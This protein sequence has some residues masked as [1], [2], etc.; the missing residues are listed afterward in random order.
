MLGVVSFTLLSAGVPCNSL[1]WSAVSCCC[2]P[3]AVSCHVKQ[4]GKPCDT[5]PDNDLP[6]GAGC[7]PALRRAACRPG[8][9]ICSLGNAASSPYEKCCAFAAQQLGEHD[10][11]HLAISKTL[12]HMP[13]SLVILNT[14]HRCSSGPHRSLLQGVCIVSNTFSVATSSTH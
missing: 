8:T 14:P 11:Q 6:R 9:C 4:G 10:C 13:C 3:P 12:H 2:L 1:R 5:L 7:R